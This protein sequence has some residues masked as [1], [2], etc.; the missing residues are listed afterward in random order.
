MI[1]TYYCIIIVPKSLSFRCAV[2]AFI[3]P[4]PCGHPLDRRQSSRQTG[5]IRQYVASQAQ[6]RTKQREQP[7]SPIKT[8]PL[9]EVPRSDYQEQGEVETT[10]LGYGIQQFKTWFQITSPSIRF[11]PISWHRSRSSGSR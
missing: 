1:M 9:T 4:F 2:A 5:D 11:G 3:S 7:D 6:E 10:D 8:C